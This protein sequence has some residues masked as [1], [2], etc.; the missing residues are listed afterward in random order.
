[1]RRLIQGGTIL[2][3]D[4]G[5]GFLPEGDVLVEENAFWPLGHRWMSVTQSGWTPRAV[6]CCL[7]W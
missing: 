6:S 7:A 3:M 4:D 1:M 5:I 2:S